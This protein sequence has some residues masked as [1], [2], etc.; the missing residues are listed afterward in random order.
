M[1]SNVLLSVGGLLVVLLALGIGLVVTGGRRA[2]ELQAANGPPPGEVWLPPNSPKLASIGVDTVR[3]R[4][5][6]VV[7][8]LPAQLALDEDHTVRVASPVSG[9]VRTLDAAPGDRVAP[10]GALAHILSS[11]VAQ[12]QS[13][14][15]R[16]E[17]TLTTA[18]TSLARARDLFA[19]HV[20]AQRDLQQAL[21]DSTQARAE[22]DRAQARVQQLGAGPDVGQE[23][24]L[25]APIGG[26]VVDRVANPGMEVRPDLPAPL[27][28]VSRLDTLWLT[29][30][31]YERDLNTVRRGQRLQF[32]TEAL[33]G[34]TIAARIT[35]V[36]SALDPVTRTATLRALVP[37]ASRALHP[38][39]FGEVRIIAPDS[40]G[41]PVVPTLALVTQ[42]DATVVFVQTAPGRF[43]L[44]SVHV[45]NDDGETAVVVDGL[46]P[47]EVIV[48]RGSL[49]LS[50]EAAP[51]R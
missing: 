8:V 2:G 48:T 17:A 41:L 47:G 14:L 34:R 40:S 1:R 6:K 38:S 13:D 28:T 20:V 33:P 49:L 43:A 16:A 45:T 3:A 19:H 30:N 26:E 18:I 39:M 15:Q 51:V 23:Y 9:R 12:A 10:G 50:A 29:A 5:E 22:R 4:S 27:F 36:S 42:G 11:D 21:N 32:T 31:V 7:A 35:H 25:R 46:R 37:N 24:V 44:R